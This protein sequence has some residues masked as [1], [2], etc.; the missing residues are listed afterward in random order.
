MIEAEFA[1]LANQGVGGRRIGDEEILKK[2]VAAWE[3]ERKT[4]RRRR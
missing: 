4:N 3:R 1:A 2:E